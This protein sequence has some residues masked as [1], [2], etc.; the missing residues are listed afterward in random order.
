MVNV[1]EYYKTIKIIFKRQQNEEHR[2][3]AS[4]VQ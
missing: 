2:N 4:F 3:L 1:I